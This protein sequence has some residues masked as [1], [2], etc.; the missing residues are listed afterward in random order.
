MRQSQQRTESPVDT[1]TSPSGN[2]ASWV[3]DRLHLNSFLQFLS[4]KRVPRHKHSFWYIFGG[5]TL[6]FF[7]I[8]LVTGMM[9]L[10][11]YSAT[12]NTAH[13]SVTFLI[14]Q[15]PFGW[16]MRTLHSWSAN[17]MV[18]TMFVHLFSVYFMKAYRKPREVM[19]FS[20]VILLFLVLGFA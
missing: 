8:Q 18:G 19:W 6:F 17:L 13:E 14:N 16:L 2:L 7:I 11:Y 15:V 9:L 3:D 4:R 12:P 5:L 10:L 20:G 1:D